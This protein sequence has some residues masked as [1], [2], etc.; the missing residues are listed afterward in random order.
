MEEKRVSKGRE[1]SSDNE[2]TEE[3]RSKVRRENKR[4]VQSKERIQSELLVLR[5]KEEVKKRKEDK[6]S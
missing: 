1:S 4:C 5:C 6:R 2:S 3:V